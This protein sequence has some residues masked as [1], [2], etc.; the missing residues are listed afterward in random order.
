M[1]KTRIKWRKILAFIAPYLA[2][3]LLTSFIISNQL[4][5]HA[6][7]IT[8][9][10]YFHF[11]R[12]YDTAEQIRTGNYSYFQNNYTSLQS[13]RIINALYGPFFAYLNGFIVLLC[14]NWFT[15]QILMDYVVYLIAGMAIYRMSK[16]VS[17]PTAASILLALIY[18]TVGIM[19]GWIR[20]D[21]FM[22]WGA[23]LAP[24]V[25]MCG[26]DMIRDTKNPVHW[27]RLMVIMS[28]LAQ[29]HM[30]STMIL[31]ISLVPFALYALITAINKK[32]VIINF[33][34]AVGGTLILTA[35]IWGGFLLLYGTN[36]LALPKSFRLMSGALRLS[37]KGS[38]HGQVPLLVLI[39]LI[40]QVIYVLFHLKE[41]K[42]NTF[43][44]LEGSI[45]LLI[46]SKLM[47]WRLIQHLLPT[48]GRSFQFPYR[49]MVAGYPLLF[50]GIGLTIL[51]LRKYKLSQFIS[52]IGLIAV[53]CQTTYFTY[54]TNVE[55]TKIYNNSSRVAV[56]S[57]YYQ[58]TNHRLDI[59]EATKSHDMGDLFKKINRSE[60]DY[61]PIYGKSISPDMVNLLYRSDIIDQSINYHYAVHGSTLY[62]K[63]HSR[64]N[65]KVRLPLVMYHQSR[66]KVNGNII[67]LPHLSSIGSPTVKEK[68]GINVASLRFEVP[69]WFWLL[70]SISLIGWF[71]L[72]VLGIRDYI[73]RRT[74]E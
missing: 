20:A 61:L 16:K 5:H 10:R 39:L 27:V 33:I 34:K 9:D 32:Q 57:T 17:V 44:T 40:A 56:L 74:L 52:Y 47:P 38:E 6:T 67:G 30:L 42:L 66:L 21:N 1:T 11:S 58:I 19:P 45:I 18:L 51:E 55:L 41:N 4:I 65:D 64:R 8:A 13:G 37:Y 73:K 12:F 25:I 63:W 22:A 29:I 71:L 31:A 3:V 2:I 23:A 72:I 36:R 53:L 15:Y 69:S 7:F 49:L 24:Y 28:I 35:N 68:Q 48:L 60:P 54:K 50:L 14:G 46:S 43:V 26:I 70:M 59:R 62:L